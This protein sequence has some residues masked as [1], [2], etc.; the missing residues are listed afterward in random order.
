MNR[1]SPKP[2]LVRDDLPN[3]RIHDYYTYHTTMD[4]GGHGM[5]TMVKHTIP[6]KEAEQIN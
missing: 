6:S 3:L 2:Y 1:L 4:D 5:V